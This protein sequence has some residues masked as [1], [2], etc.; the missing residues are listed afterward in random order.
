MAIKAKKRRSEY[1]KVGFA[2]CRETFSL[3]CLCDFLA[4]EI[5]NFAR[6]I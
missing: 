1:W 6:G 4:F 2:T 3:A 5:D